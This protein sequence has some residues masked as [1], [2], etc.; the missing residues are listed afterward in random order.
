MPLASSPSH[1]PLVFKSVLLNYERNERKLIL[2]PLFRES[3]ISPRRKANCR[4]ATS[5]LFLNHLAYRISSCSRGHLSYCAFE[6]VI[7]MLLLRREYARKFPRQRMYGHLLINWE[8][9]TSLRFRMFF[10]FFS[11]GI[12]RRNL[13]LWGL[14]RF[15]RPQT[16]GWNWE[17]PW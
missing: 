4:D 14:V 9:L 3:G 15:L 16:K 5:K 1:L 12:T 2:A 17:S 8:L 6:S 11:S 10:D 13:R 7:R